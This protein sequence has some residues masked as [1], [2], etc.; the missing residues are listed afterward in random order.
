MH[1][2]C[3]LTWLSILKLEEANKISYVLGR[4]GDKVVSGVGSAVQ[5]AIEDILE[6]DLVSPALELLQILH[7]HRCKRY[8]LS[9][10]GSPYGATCSDR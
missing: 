9:H 7:L 8:I 2:K 6:E 1:K 3:K 5:E 4:A 10:I